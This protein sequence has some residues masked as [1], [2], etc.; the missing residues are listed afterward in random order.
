MTAPLADRRLSLPHPH[1]TVR[2][3]RGA[4][5]VASQLY[6]SL[7]T[8]ALVSI[9]AQDRRARETQLL[10][11]CVSRKR[12]FLSRGCGPRGSGPGPFEGTCGRV[13]SGIRAL[14]PPPAPPMQ[15][16]FQRRTASPAPSKAPAKALANLC[17]PTCSQSIPADSCLRPRAQ[18]PLQGPATGAPALRRQPLDLWNILSQES[19]TN[20][21]PGSAA[22][23]F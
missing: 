5:G 10:A 14:A 20:T 3:P 9:P 2:F 18:S 16:P 15:E 7:D 23:L 1:P 6:P 22:S 21:N 19:T 8:S 11:L 12:L 17:L 13:G 4:P